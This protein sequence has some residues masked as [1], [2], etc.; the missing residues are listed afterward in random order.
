MREMSLRSALALFFGVAL[1]FMLFQPVARADEWNEM[2]KLKFNR[3]VELPHVV[4]PAGS[5]WFT[6][7]NSSSDRNIVEVFS[8]D[9]KHEYAT[10]LTIPTYRPHST[11]YTVL[12]FAERRHDLPEALL[13]WYYPG[14]LTGQQFVYSARNE[15]KFTRDPKQTVDANSFTSRS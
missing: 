8:T 1:A 9:W 5:Y 2:T 11:D 7:A 4:L 13:K 15:H 6:L 10:L 12:K 14:R 3:P